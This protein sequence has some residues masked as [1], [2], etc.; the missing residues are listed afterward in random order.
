MVFTNLESAT[1]L[2]SAS[3]ALVQEAD[4]I[5]VEYPYGE[6]TGTDTYLVDI[7]GIEAY[8]TGMAFL[9]KFVNANTGS[10][11]LNVNSLGALTLKKSVS[12]NLAASD[13]A[14]GAILKV[15][16]DGTN[17]QVIGLGGGGSGTP[18]GSDTQVQFND[19]G[20]FGGDADW[21]YNKT[22]NIQT[23]KGGIIVSDETASRIAH[24]DS[25][26]QIKGLDTSTYPNLTELSY[27]KGLIA[28]P[29]RILLDATSTPVSVNNAAGTI[30]R[31]FLI[32]ANTLQAD[33]IIEIMLT[34]SK[35]G[36]GAVMDMR[37]SHNTS[38]SISGAT[39]FLR[40]QFASTNLYGKI[41]RHLI[42]TS[43]SSQVIYNSAG[44]NDSDDV[45]G[46]NSA[47]TTLSIDL[48]VDNYF[49]IHNGTAIPLSD[50]VTLESTYTELI[51]I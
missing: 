30:F 11:T 9:I 48:T 5:T 2:K 7:D 20:A 6:T 40:R 49:I 38:N 22:S 24:F 12:T 3:L 29:S 39:N 31:S 13:I 19:G 44:L 36:T 4:N 47:I 8:T 35:V 14:A 32:P 10:S 33:D 46:A 41:S 25:S 42:I 43:T 27:I 21:T 50:T 17:L 45:I 16:Y 34:F 28:K 37:M 26:K 15:V 18:G 51:R 23:I 1:V